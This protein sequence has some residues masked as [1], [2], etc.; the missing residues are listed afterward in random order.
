MAMAEVDS[1]HLKVIFQRFLR[2]FLQKAETHLTEG[3]LRY[4]FGGGG[5]GGGGG[6]I[7]GGAAAGLI[8]GGAY[9]RNFTV[10]SL[11]LLTPTRADL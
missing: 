4:E 6:L 5:G 3:S 7:L 1:F 2:S 8:H 9:F 10:P 11:G